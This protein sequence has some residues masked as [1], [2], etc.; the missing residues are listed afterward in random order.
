MALQGPGGAGC[1]RHTAKDIRPLAAT[2]Q[3][4]AMWI[5]TNTQKP[6][7][8]LGFEFQK[9]N[10]SNPQ[11][12]IGLGGG[13]WGATAREVGPGGRPL[14]ATRQPNTKYAD[15]SA[16]AERCVGAVLARA[17]LLWEP[18]RWQKRVL[19][20]K[21]GLEPTPWGLVCPNAAMVS[22]VPLFLPWSFSWVQRGS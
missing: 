13:P 3:L 2:R 5:F 12:Q 1:R 14:A 6:L 21:L 9:L 22:A 16:K 20:A 8:K 4:G 17:V 10:F 11:H 15:T 18:S 7:K 19:H